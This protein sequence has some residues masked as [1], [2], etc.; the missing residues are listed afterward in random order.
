MWNAFRHQT[1]AILALLDHIRL[2]L[3]PPASPPTQK[4]RN[5]RQNPAP[6]RR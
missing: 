5:S 2:H 6:S 1:K 3:P 4:S